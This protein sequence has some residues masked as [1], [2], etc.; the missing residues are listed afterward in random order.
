MGVV[1]ETYVRKPLYVEAVRVTE[2]NFD[3]LVAWCQGEV[4][5]GEMG[6]KQKKYIKVRVHHP[7]KNPRQTQAFVGDWLLYTEFGGYKVYTNK[8]FR[9]TFDLVEEETPEL[10]AADAVIEP[11]R[12]ASPET[13]ARAQEQQAVGS[14]ETPQ[15]E[16]HEYVEATPKAIADAVGG[17][18]PIEASQQPGPGPVRGPEPSSGPAVRGPDPVTPQPDPVSEQAPEDAA[19]GKRVLSVEEQR[20]MGPDAVREL[21]QSGEAVLAQDLAA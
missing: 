13:V 7:T 21:I 17:H 1:T 6:G 2:A 8:A 12:A 9:A 19:A 18:Q 10:P 11:L 3:E 4:L 16:P 15:G 5:S 20:Q 14:H